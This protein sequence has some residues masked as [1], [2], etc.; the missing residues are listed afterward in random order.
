MQSKRLSFSSEAMRWLLGRDYRGN[1]RELENLVE[2]AVT[3]AVG[4]R[5]EPSDL[6]YDAGGP[7]GGMRWLPV[8]IPDTGFDLDAHLAEIERRILV[9]A[10]EKTNGV[11]KDA[12]K[13]LGT[14]FRSL[15]YRLAKYEMGDGDEEGG[16]EAD[17][18]GTLEG[19]GP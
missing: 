4:P 3:L 6:D 13:L 19:G 5:V 14:T 10:L 9:A 11:R 2:R 16:G 17:E 1:V 8:E 15:R 12:A 18:R 7:Q